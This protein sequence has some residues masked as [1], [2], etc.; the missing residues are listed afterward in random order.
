[1]F[2]FGYNGN[3]LTS[4]SIIVIITP[5]FFHRTTK[6]I[7]YLDHHHQEIDVQ[8]LQSLQISEIKVFSI[9]T[10]LILPAIFHSGKATEKSK[11][12]LL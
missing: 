7:I 1:M 6:I 9:H 5:S 4:T 10:H 8:D 12:G 11:I 3:Q 2:I